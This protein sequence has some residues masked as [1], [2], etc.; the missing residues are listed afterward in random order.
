MIKTLPILLITV[1]LAPTTLP[2]VELTTVNFCQEIK[3]E[4]TYSSED[5][6][7]DKEAVQ[8]IYDRCMEIM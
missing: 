3:A 7:I 2:N 8:A 4:L 5:I 1:A 6:G